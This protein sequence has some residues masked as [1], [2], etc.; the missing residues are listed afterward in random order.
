MF[1]HVFKLIDVE[2]PD[3]WP[4]MTYA[5]AMRRYGSDKPDLRFD[6]ELID[7]GDALRDTDFAPFADALKA[8]GEI[9][10]I[11]VKGRADYSR[12]KRTSP[13]IRQTLRSRRAGV[14]QG[15]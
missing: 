1:N 6:M 5:D 10:C 8:G 15:W 13:R 7:L 4:R 2:L 9:K 14:G 12:N 3:V 11:V